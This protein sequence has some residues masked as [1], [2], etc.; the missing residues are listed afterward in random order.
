[1]QFTKIEKEKLGA[2]K[3]VGVART[4]IAER[5]HSLSWRERVERERNGIHSPSSEGS[6]EL[7]ESWRSQKSS[8]RLLQISM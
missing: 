7:R 1:M 3:I 8:F 5:V 4:A 6:A 2:W